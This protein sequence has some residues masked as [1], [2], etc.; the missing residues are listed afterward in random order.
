MDRYW[1]LT[2]TCYGNR[3]PGDRRGFVG[4]V[5]DHRPDDPDEK[6]RVAHNVPGTPCDED[7][8]GLERESRAAMKGPPILL[9]PDQAEIFLGQF[10]ETADFRGW[11]VY[12]VAVMVDHFHIVV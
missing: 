11:E 2:N 6:P 5:W 12:A 8:P 7:L 4:R 3:L 9:T 10:R 1:L